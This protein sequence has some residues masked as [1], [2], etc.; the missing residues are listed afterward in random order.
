MNRGLVM[1]GAGIL[2]A[3]AGILP[4]RVGLAH[5]SGTATRASRYS[6]G[7]DAQ[8]GGQDARATAELRSAFTFVEVLAA[9][10]FLGILLPAIMAGITHS[11][12]ASIVADRTA[13]A[14]QLA[15]NQLN[16]LLLNDAW[17]T[18]DEHGQFGEDWPGYNW[19]LSH[20]DWEGGGMVEL[21][22]TVTFQVQGKPR[23]VRLTT[24]AIDPQ[25]I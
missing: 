25:A 16:E 11:N 23:E 12:R 10:T 20:T 6:L 5:V 8:A 2:P 14:M 17:T 15:D 4:A 3:R 1:G 7:Q 18:A 9:L 21:N 13:V 24:L 19:E 22:L